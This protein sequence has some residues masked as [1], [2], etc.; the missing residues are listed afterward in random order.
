MLITLI[1]QT[2]TSP[3]PEYIHLAMGKPVRLQVEEVNNVL[4][5]ALIP[6]K[7]CITTVKYHIPTLT[8]KVIK[9]LFKLNLNIM[10]FLIKKSTY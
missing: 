10:L 7:P 8:P 6:I 9:N 1:N 4:Y 2:E 5:D 3:D